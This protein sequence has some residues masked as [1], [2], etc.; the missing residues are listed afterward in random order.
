MKV[1]T[2]KT[3]QV[4]QGDI[5]RDVEM[6]ERVWEEGDELV[7]SRIVFPLVVVLTQDC[8]LA[9]DYGVR[10][11]RKK[12]N[13][14]KKLFSVLVSPLYNVEHV[15]AGTHLNDIG[16]EMAP[17]NR[18]KTVGGGLRQ[19]ETPRYH[20]LEFPDSVPIV[21]SVI[22][23]KH[24]F[25]ACVTTLKS[26]GF[27]GLSSIQYRGVWLSKRGSILHFPNVLVS[28]FWGLEFSY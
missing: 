17:I 10:W 13:D 19:N 26:Q 28:S 20:Y 8:D 2:Q 4:S 15:Y 5:F 11:S 6:V 21:P 1:R 25:S 23:F 16:Q 22:D 18:K 24:Y 12:T 3:P 27:Q 7:V 14:D 9:Q